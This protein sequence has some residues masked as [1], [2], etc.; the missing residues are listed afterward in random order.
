[1]TLQELPIDE[2]THA[3]DVVDVEALASSVHHRLHVVLLALSLGVDFLD[4][5]VHVHVRVVELASV[6]VDVLLLVLKEL[7]WV[8]MSIRHLLICHL[9]SP[10]LH[11]RH[12]S[13][14]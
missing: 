9:C 7:D 4:G 13:T 5:V 3:A 14:C 10:D 2:T 12:L 6:S 11:L 1:M 8:A